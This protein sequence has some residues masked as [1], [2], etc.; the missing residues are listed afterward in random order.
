MSESSEQPAQPLEQYVVI[1]VAP[2]GRRT[3][4]GARFVEL[5]DAAR[6]A[7]WE[8]ERLAGSDLRWRAE[9]LRGAGS[10][11]GSPLGGEGP[12]G[13]WHADARRL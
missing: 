2:D 9:I 8:L 3:S 13:R 4:R 1:F 12:S 7:E 6:W 5:E 10:E 11:P